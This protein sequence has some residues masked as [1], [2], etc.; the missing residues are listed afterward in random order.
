MNKTI[1]THF[2]NEEF[3]LP[4]WLNHHKRYFDH[5]ILINYGSTDRSIEII[6]E[7]CP[8][9]EIIDSKHEYFDHELCDQE[10]QNTEFKVPHLGW[11]CSIPIT[12]FAVGNLDKLMYETNEY[13][14]M[15]FLLVVKFTGYDPEGYIDNTKPLWTQITQGIRP[16]TDNDS[17]SLQNCQ[18]VSY[19]AGRH[20]WGLA[21]TT[22]AMIFKYA[23][24]LIGPDMIK[25]KLQIQYKVSE[26][27]KK[28][29]Y[30]EQH[31]FSKMNGLTVENLEI[32]YKETI[33]S[34]NPTDCSDF[35]SKLNLID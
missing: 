24:C 33:L 29:G 15:H 25:R 21:N 18:Y 19:P 9:W 12:E 5:G 6:K 7:V 13:G 20:F 32:F 31:I 22:E 23:A 8:S 35:I 10:I 1:I 11:R 4:L 27:D 30:A 14:V 26:S 16:E 17:R 34:R 2:Y 28:N 3:L